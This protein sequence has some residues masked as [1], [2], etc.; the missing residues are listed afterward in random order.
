MTVSVRKERRRFV[1][2]GARA[3]QVFGL[4]KYVRSRCGASTSSRNSGGQPP[5]MP[6]RRCAINIWGDF[7]HAP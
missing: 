4:L 5:P 2:V 3:A 7:G 1:G 6:P